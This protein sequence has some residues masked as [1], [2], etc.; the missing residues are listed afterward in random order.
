MKTK[1]KPSEITES[2]IVFECPSCSKSLCIDFHGAGLKINCPQCDEIILVPGEAV[3]DQPAGDSPLEAALV[4]S[5]ARI[6]H[7]TNGLQNVREQR[8][9]LLKQREQNEK[10]IEMFR[11]EA[12]R[13]QDA[14]D[15]INQL[16]V[17]AKS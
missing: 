13:L 14:L 3:E 8:N 1:S 6:K 12:G 9:E 7:L 16:L 4:S 2:D 11:K 15:R 17:D 10:Q 5:E